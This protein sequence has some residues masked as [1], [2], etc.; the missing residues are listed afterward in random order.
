MQQFKHR[1]GSLPL[2]HDGDHDHRGC[3]STNANAVNRKQAQ[4]EQL[5]TRPTK[6][7]KTAHQEL[8]SCSNRNRW[9]SVRKS[10]SAGF[11]KIQ[12]VQRK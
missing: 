4:L 6:P 5:L 2:V 10:F 12:T 8:C 7:C 9:A 1:K 11:L 3:V